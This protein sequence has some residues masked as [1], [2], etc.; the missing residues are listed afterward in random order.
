MSNAPR[1]LARRTLSSLSAFLR[2]TPGHAVLMYHRIADDIQDPWDLCVSPDN[3]RAQILWMQ[4]QGLR[5]STVADLARRIERGEDTRQRVAIS[6]D[7]GYADNYLSA[8]PILAELGVPATFFIATGYV[9]TGREFWWDAVERLFLQPGQ[10]AEIMKVAGA[11]EPLVLNLAGA[12]DYSEA[13]CRSHWDWRWDDAPPT[14]RHKALAQA[15]HHLFRLPPAPRDAALAE[16]LGH[17]G[18]AED[19]IPSRRAMTPAELRA[20]ASDPRMEIGAHTVNHPNLTVL[21]R[22]AKAEEIEGS[23][24]ALE[25]LTGCEVL[26]IAYPNGCCD[27][28]TLELMVEAKFK[29]GCRNCPGARNAGLFELSRFIVNNA[30]GGAL[31]PDIHWHAGLKIQG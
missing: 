21:D 22:A 3:F 16:L 28:E 15:W 31:S 4:A 5:F 20:L 18:R 9:E 19:A 12:T 13:E 10:L 11:A 25:A 1:G 26:G 30:Q 14:A 29:Y 8:Y 17:A 2:R 23:R 7:D 6:F 27:S 24:R